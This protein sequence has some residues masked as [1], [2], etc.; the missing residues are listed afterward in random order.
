MN[1]P[2]DRAF[3]RA[4]GTFALF[5]AAAVHAPA[6]AQAVN[7]GNTQSRGAKIQGQAIYDNVPDYVESPPGTFV[8]N[9]LNFAA[10]PSSRPTPGT[11]VTY[12]WSQGSGSAGVL[13]PTSGMSTQFTL[14]DVVKPAGAPAG[15]TG[16][17]MTVVLTIT[18]TAA[19]C[20]GTWSSA[21]TLNVL[22]IV[23]PAANLPPTAVAAASAPVTDEGTQV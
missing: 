14:P 16:E 18:S 12:T 22:D 20:P 5:V 13:S 4:L 6:H 11:G 19:G 7:C 21:V 1:T 23:V 10:N 2:N 8:R 9:A 15:W 17:V 3:V